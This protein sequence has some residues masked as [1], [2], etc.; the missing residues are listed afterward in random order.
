MQNEETKQNVTAEQSAAL[1]RLAA[2]AA[3]ITNAD[4]GKRAT[5]EVNNGY[6]FRIYD[7]KS[8]DTLVSLSLKEA[9]NYPACL[10]LAS[11]IRMTVE[12]LSMEKVI[13]EQATRQEKGYKTACEGLAKLRE[14]A[15]GDPA[16]LAFVDRLAGLVEAVHETEAPSSFDSQDFAMAS[17]G[18]PS[19]DELDDYAASAEPETN[20]QQEGEEA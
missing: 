13:E 16:K 18:A 10:E 20:T 4:N 12:G 14:L 17:A 7:A 2:L 6:S 8:Y 5:F 9:P 11:F 1:G 3:D 19:E 15:A